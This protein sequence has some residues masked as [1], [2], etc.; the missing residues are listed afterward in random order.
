MLLSINTTNLIRLKILAEVIIL[1]PHSLRS[2]MP[3]AGQLCS[4]LQLHR[5]AWAAWQALAVWAE[6][7]VA[8]AMVVEWAGWDKELLVVKVV[9]TSSRREFATSKA[10]KECH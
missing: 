10:N 6:V 4:V 5:A 7:T 9:R 1:M 2:N 8:Q 3:C